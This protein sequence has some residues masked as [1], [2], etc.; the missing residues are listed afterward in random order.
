M[1]LFATRKHTQQ[2]HSGLRGTLGEDFQDAL[3]ARGD[4]FG[5]L[6][7]VSG[8]V[9]TD[10]HHSDLGF[11]RAKIPSLQPPNHMLGAVAG[12]SRSRRSTG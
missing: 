3:D 2:Q 11:R 5:R 6:H 7:T 1:R 10:H 8:I 9:R 4:L 12:K